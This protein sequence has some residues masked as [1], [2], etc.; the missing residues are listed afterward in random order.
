MTEYV[1]EKCDRSGG[2]DRDGFGIEQ[3]TNPRQSRETEERDLFLL[4]GKDFGIVGPTVLFSSR[5][6]LIS[7]MID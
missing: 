7:S 4:V 2:E 5:S 3:T 1:L 6:R